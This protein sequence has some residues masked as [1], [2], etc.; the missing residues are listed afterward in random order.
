MERLARGVLQPPARL[1][2]RYFRRHRRVA[3][4]PQDD[5]LGQSRRRNTSTTIFLE[6]AVSGFTVRPPRSRAVCP[7]PEPLKASKSQQHRN[8]KHRPVKKSESGE[9]HGTE[10]N[11]ELIRIL[12]G[13]GRSVDSMTGNKPLRW[14]PRPGPR[15]SP[16]QHQS[17]QTQKGQSGAPETV[18]QT[19]PV[20][21][22]LDVPTVL[23][24]CCKAVARE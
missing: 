1:P 6:S 17:A 14:R 23:S 20:R 13:S 18:L 3:V 4:S 7:R 10:A 11:H 21:R 15:P 16:T 22:V 19:L 5:I 9:P 24:A 8:Q 2:G 12:R